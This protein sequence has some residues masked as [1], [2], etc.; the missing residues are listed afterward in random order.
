MEIIMTMNTY[1]VDWSED[2]R[3]PYGLLKVKEYGTNLPAAK[4][5]ARRK[6][7]KPDILT[8]YVIK[9]ID[10]VDVGQWAF[11]GGVTYGFE[12]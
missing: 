4:A 7:E 6:S 3:G 12:S 11:S 5:F 2:S 10:G 8:A 9:S 1:R